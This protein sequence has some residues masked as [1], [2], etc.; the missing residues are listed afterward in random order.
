MMVN[1][2]GPD[3]IV[4]QNRTLCMIGIIIL[5]Y[6]RDPTQTQIIPLISNLIGP[7]NVV[8]DP[9]IKTNLNSL[10][11]ASKTRE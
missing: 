10:K 7:V 5:E 8:I 3:S 4:E 11:D 6:P 9:T 1:I 2:P